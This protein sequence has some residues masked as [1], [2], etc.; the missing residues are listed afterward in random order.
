[1]NHNDHSDLFL[2]ILTALLFQYVRDILF[3]IE[4]VFITFEVC[5]PEHS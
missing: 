5:I 3:E 2:A 1:M 4:S